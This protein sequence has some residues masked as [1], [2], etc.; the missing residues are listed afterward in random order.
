MK[1]L[2]L[3]V[4]VMAALVSCDSGS[5]TKSITPTSAEYESDSYMDDEVESDDDWDELLDSYE[6]YVDKYI[7]YMKKAANGDMSALAEYPS[8]MEKAEEFSEELESA[9]LELSD[10]QMARYM[11]ISN[12][13]LSAAKDIS[14]ESSVNDEDESDE[15]E[16]DEDWDELLDSYEEYVENYLSCLRRAANGHM[17]AVEAVESLEETGKKFSKKLQGAKSDL[18]ASQWSRYMK[19]SD[20]MISKE[21][22]ILNGELV[23]GMLPEE[24]QFR[25]IRP[26]NIFMVPNISSATYEKYTV[27][28]DDG[29]N[30][31]FTDLYSGAAGWYVGGLVRNIVASSALKSQGSANYKVANIHDFNHETAWVEGVKDYGVGEWIEYQGVSGNEIYGIKIL[32]GYVKSDKAWSENARVKR[33]KVYCDGT[34]VCILE[35]ENSRSLQSFNVKNLFD[36]QGVKTFKFEILEVYPGTKYKDTVISEIYFDGPAN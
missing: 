31:L 19:I 32:N 15:V 18:S 3:A 23:E 36:E 8:L 27:E 16:S 10:S 6:E 30:P 9:K 12:K 35:L 22:D 28:D 2:F 11:K 20:K 21:Q 5:K 14:D 25:I 17:D 24:E 34:P 29:S 1:K 4:V 33:L 26:S 13:M 7:S